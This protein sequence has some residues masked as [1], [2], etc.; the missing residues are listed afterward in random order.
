MV[1]NLWILDLI[2]AHQQE[3]IVFADA[4]YQKVG[5]G[6]VLIQAESP[7]EFCTGYV[8]SAQV[9]ASEADPDRKAALLEAIASY[10]PQQTIVCCCV[11][12]VGQGFCE[13]VTVLIKKDAHNT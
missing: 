3:A 11:A 6:A 5:P 4:A 13:I 2:Y 7:Q 1:K 9:N 8:T 10:D 12:H